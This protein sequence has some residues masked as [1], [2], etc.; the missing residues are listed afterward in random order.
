MNQIIRKLL[1]LQSWILYKLQQTD[2]Q[3]DGG[4]AKSP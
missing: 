1:S 2:N 4:V 3:I